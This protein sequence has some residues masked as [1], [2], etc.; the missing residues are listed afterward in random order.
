MTTFRDVTT[1]PAMGIVRQVQDN[2]DESKSLTSN[3]TTK[4]NIKTFKKGRT[5]GIA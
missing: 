4:M 3:G 5:N 1:R 2:G